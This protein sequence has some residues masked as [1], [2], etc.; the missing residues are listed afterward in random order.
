MQE[1]FELWKQ[2]IGELGEIVGYEEALSI[3]DSITDLMLGVGPDF[4]GEILSCADVISSLSALQFD[5]LIDRLTEA[6]AIESE[7]KRE[8]E[9][10]LVL[11][12]ER[13]LKEWDYEL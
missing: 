13:I 3:S 7:I 11:E 2:K 12:R 10:E 9:Y 5:I 6:I 4:G 1:R 8:R